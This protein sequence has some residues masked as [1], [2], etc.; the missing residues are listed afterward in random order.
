MKIKYKLCIFGLVAIMSLGSCRHESDTRSFSTENVTFE[1]TAPGFKISDS[2]KNIKAIQLEFNDTCAIGTIEK[3]FK[4]EDELVV[5]TQQDEVFCFDKNSGKFLGQL[6]RRGEGPDEYNVIVDVYYNSKDKTIN[7]ISSFPSKILSFN[8]EGKLLN[9]ER[10]DL[11]VDDAIESIARSNDGW[12]LM[13]HRLAGGATPTEYAYTAVS[14]TG[15]E[16]SFDPFAPIKAGNYTFPFAYQSAVALG[17][18]ITFFKFMNDTIFAMKDGEISPLYHLELKKKFPQR[19]ILAQ[20]GNFAEASLVIGLK[21]EYFGGFEKIFETK[22]YIVLTSRIEFVGGQFWIDKETGKG[23]HFSETQEV[24]PMM[25]MMLKGEIIP[26]IFGSNENEIISVLD[27]S[28]IEVAN[29]ALKET[30]DLV[31][32]S[33]EIKNLLENA[34][35]EGNPVVIIYSH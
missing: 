28:D 18:E 29:K 6:S 24:K 4:A 13:S 8:A 31:P 17:D 9:S 2:F 34:D 5:L 3:I 16:F 26:N 7:I 15:D 25:A 22:R 10:T 32:F 21:G 33:E 35:P 19:E 23:Y 27:V 20:M 14:P 12:M 1:E 11:P 30:S